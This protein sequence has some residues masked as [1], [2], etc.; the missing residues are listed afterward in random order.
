MRTGAIYFGLSAVFTWLTMH[1]QQIL[2]ADEWGSYEPGTNGY[3]WSQPMRTIA[4]SSAVLA[5][6]MFA[7]GLGCIVV[8]AI[9]ANPFKRKNIPR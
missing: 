6:L 2:L 7:I 4:D 5:G 1:C 8:S 9:A 3:A